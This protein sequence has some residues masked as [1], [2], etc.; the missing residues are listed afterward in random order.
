MADE[1]HYPLALNGTRGVAVETRSRTGVMVEH[2]I[3]DICASRE[4]K[5][6]PT[7]TLAVEI[8]RGL[9]SMKIEDL[10]GYIDATRARGTLS[11]T[12]DWIPK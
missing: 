12:S 3:K 4:L 5:D 7:L 1:I 9:G 8:M 11:A 10:I 6:T 2:L